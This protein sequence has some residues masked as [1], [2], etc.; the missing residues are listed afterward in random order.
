MTKAT[1]LWALIVDLK[2]TFRLPVASQATY[3]GAQPTA[4]AAALRELGV[5]LIMFNTVPDGTA[6]RLLLKM[7]PELVPE[8]TPE[9]Q[10]E[11]LMDEAVARLQRE[12]HI[13][14]SKIVAR[15]A[16]WVANDL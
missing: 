10:L 4:M 5:D 15:T 16:M 12:R 3:I 6:A 2:P 1:H 13:P 9:P 7:D 8:S 14:T 11:A